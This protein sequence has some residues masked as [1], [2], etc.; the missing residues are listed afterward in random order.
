M[1][2]ELENY[3][4]FNEFF[5][6]ILTSLSVM[7]IDEFV[8]DIFV[9]TTYSDFKTMTFTLQAHQENRPTLNMSGIIHVPV[10]G[11]H[12]LSDLWKGKLDSLEMNIQ[13]ENLL[14]RYINY[15]KSRQMKIPSEL[16]KGYLKLKNI[17]NSL[18]KLNQILR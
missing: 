16:K 11:A 12:Q 14:N 18:P 10:V 6:K 1:A 2:S 17:P 15:V 5:N 7:G 9:N 8:G 3:I 4:P 13:D